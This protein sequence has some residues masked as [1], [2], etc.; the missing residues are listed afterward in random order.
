MNDNALWENILEEFPVK[1]QLAYFHS[2]GMSPM[3]TRV[4][5]AV[6]KAYK[7]LNLYGDMYFLHDLQRVEELLKRLATMI[8]TSENNVCFTQNSSLAYA[9]LASSLKKYA[10]EGFNF[11]SLH[12]EFPSSVVPYEFQGIPIKYV[13]PVNGV[14]T[15]EMIMEAVDENTIG[16]LCSYVQYSNGFRLEIE[17]LGQ[18]VKE[19]GLLFIVNA[20]QAFPI[21]DIDT[22]RM[23]ID[24]LTVSF[25]KWGLCGV[26]GT[27]F[28]TS[29]EFRKKYPSTM[30]GW[31]GV[32]PPAN[33]FIPTQKEEGFEQLAHAGQY[34]FGTMNFQAYAGLNEAITFM[35]EIGR[36][37]I[38]E[39]I[40]QLTS[41]LLEKLKDIPAEILSPVDNPDHRSPIILINLK[42]ASNTEA[43]E[44][45]RK[46]NIITAIRAGNI[47]ISC[48]FFNDKEEIDRL[49]RVLELYCEL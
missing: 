12:D 48:N 26:A 32:K 16:V 3:P 27:L 37:K 22:E 43:V 38:R 1:K 13:K 23:H 6:V 39:R 4:Y 30:A 9:F 19:K 25:H 24:A 7:S 28:F 44:F 41:Y 10:P 31:L 42:G 36:E 8:H 2:A 14:Y 20:T 5:E 29:E 11:V 35:E 47:R 49:I 18:M 40:D 15:P 33:D 17:K 46:H 34:N 45:L 21:Y